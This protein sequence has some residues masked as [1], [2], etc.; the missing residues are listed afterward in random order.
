M[1]D[2]Q[3]QSSHECSLAAEM[4]Q[5]MAKKFRE[6]EGHLLPQTEVEFAGMLSIAFMLGRKSITSGTEIQEGRT[7][8]S[9]G[10]QEVR[11]RHGEPHVPPAASP[12]SDDYGCTGCRST[13]CICH[14]LGNPR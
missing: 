5:E 13:P 3:P 4:G 7:G 1:T 12:D 6:R 14:E 9:R 2:V 11:T 8:P 10:T